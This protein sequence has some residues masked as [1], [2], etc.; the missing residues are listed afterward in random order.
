MSPKVKKILRWTIGVTS[1]VLFSV[2]L[3]FVGPIAGWGE[4]YPLAGFWTRTI[5]LT[6]IWGVFFGVLGWKYRKRRK[7]QKA[8]EDAVAGEQITG[9]ADELK[10]RMGD[11]ITTLRKASG[12]RNFLYDLP[13]YVIIG[14]PGTGKT[15]AL[16]NSGLKFPLASEGGTAAMAGVGGTR[17][18]D[19]WFAEDAVLIDTAGR[20]TTQD[21]EKEADEKSWTSFLSLLKETRTKQPING[22]IITISLE[23]LMTLPEEEINRHANAIR[24]RLLELNEKLKVDFPVYALFTKADLVAGFNEFFSSFPEDRRRQVWGATF[25]T[26]D[27]KKNSVGTIPKEIDDLVERL[28]EETADRLQAEPDPMARIAI[29]GFPAQVARLREPVSKFLQ[30]VFEPTRYHANAHLR[31]FYFSSGTQQGTP[32]D[33]VLGAMGA[34]MGADTSQYM[35]GKG[36]SYFLHDLLT[37]VIFQEAGWVSRDLGAIRKSS[38]FRYGAIAAMLLATAGLSGVWV[39]SYL[40]NKQ[41]V[42]TTNASIAEYRTKAGLA[43]DEDVVADADMHNV[44]D[45]LHKMRNLETG[46]DN[47]E[48]EPEWSQTFGLSQRER[49]TAASAESYHDALERT[50]RSRLIYRLEQQIQSSLAD[51]AVVYE[52]LKVYLMLGGNAPKV[53]DDFIISWMVRDWEDNLYRGAANKA[54]RDELEKHLRAMLDLGRDRTP[55]ITLNNSL[56]TSARQTL[57]RLSL[58]D[59]AFSMIKG[60]A[61]SAGLVDWSITDAGGLDTVNVFETVDGSPIEDVTIPGL[62]TYTGFQAYF[63]DQL[64]AVADNLQAENWVLGEEGKAAVDQ[65]FA[66]LGRNLLDMYRKE[67]TAA[68]EELFGKV[69]LKRMSADKPQYLAIAAASSADSPIRRLIDSVNRETRLT[70]ELPAAAEGVDPAAIADNVKGGGLVG[71]VAQIAVQRARDRAT[72]WTRIGINLAL[73]KSQNRLGAQGSGGSNAKPVVPGE[74]IEQFFRPWHQLADGE[75]GQRP[76]DLLI[77]NL[78]DIYQSLLLAATNPSQVERATANLSLQITSLRANSSRLPTPLRT[79]MEGAVSDFEGDAAGSTITQLNQALASEVTRV[80]QEVTANHYPFAADSGRDVPMMEFARLFSPNGVMDSFFA[81]QLTKYVDTSGAIWDW[82]P[83]ELIGQNM[84][85]ATLREFQ[86]ASE[87]RDAF[88]PAGSPM[89]GLN[90]TVKPSTLSGN[91]ELALMEVNGTVIQSQQVGNAPVDLTW[92]GNG[93]GSASITIFPELPDR[94]SS[95]A[96]TGQWA[97]MRL[98]SK[99][100]PTKSEDGIS[101]RFVIGGREVSYKIEVKSLRNPFTLPALGEF[102][103]PAGF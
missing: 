40:Q 65:Q 18:C 14:P 99:G 39:W 22:V 17:Y 100:A 16:V 89:I 74:D 29:F 35:S 96:E 80:C 72:G 52:A 76:I 69:R 98:V 44:L 1:L 2:A 102:K 7:A 43:I 49:L 68:W 12:A 26:D 83:D 97:F 73:E 13:W 63:L 47:R 61:P 32:I 19:W 8:L 11:A 86:R 78:Y 92:P 77:T 4:F 62:Y 24:K 55:E 91:A 20:Y 79:M 46:Y 88:F 54:G 85:K 42:D 48:K 67:F 15:T 58:A 90:M 6:L 84:S 51:P 30:S 101:V 37:K 9:D 66:V 57:V 45:I 82:K 95:V 41:L 50:L 23:D 70:A 21:S 93:A 103:C 36:R 60:Q 87:I 56:V 81:K 94:K 53:D 33:Q 38:M 31:G 28:T 59:R 64:A 27:R 3:W 75:T 71:E 5:I 34:G 25:Q 10:T